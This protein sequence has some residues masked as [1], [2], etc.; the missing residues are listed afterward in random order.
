[1][2]VPHR[3][4]AELCRDVYDP[5]VAAA[6]GHA[7]IKL[8]LTEIGEL[9][10]WAWRGTVIKDPR[11]ILRDLDDAGV[12]VAGIGRVPE[13][14]IHGVFGVL[15]P[16]AAQIRRRGR[17]HLHTG[18]SLGGWMAQPAACLLKL[19]GLAPAECTVFNAPRWA[20]AE[21]RACFAGIPGTSYRYGADQVS[22]LPP[23]EFGYGAG[24][25]VTP[26]GHPDFWQRLDLLTQ[27]AIETVI[28][29]LP[30]DRETT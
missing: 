6:L 20:D 26:L 28:D 24:R 5:A 21:G 23:Q 9:D 11:N 2:S 8:T 17:A 18:H 7:D 19:R 15:E 14:P 4:L 29:A 16:L 25:E 30:D 10:V 22:V 13:G 12:Y 3:R 27:H 1:M